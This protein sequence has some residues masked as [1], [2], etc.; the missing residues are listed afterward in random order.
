MKEETEEKD[1][2]E[3]LRLFVIEAKVSA[4]AYQYEPCNNPIEADRSFTDDQLRKYFNAYPKSV[5]DPLSI[6]IDEHLLPLGFRMV[7]DEILC[8]PVIFVKSKC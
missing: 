8:E 1:P 2:R 4:F 3:A 5:G 7:H 6:Y